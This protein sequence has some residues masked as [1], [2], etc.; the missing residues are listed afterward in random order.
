MQ[1]VLVDMKT[2]R[3]LKHGSKAALLP[4]PPTAVLGPESGPV[5]P[6][7]PGERAGR[8]PSP[9]PT[10]GGSSG[11][12]HVAAQALSLA[13]SQGA[14]QTDR[15]TSFQRGQSQP[16]GDQNG[17]ER[18]VELGADP[19]AS[20]GLAGCAPVFRRRLRFGDGLAGGGA[21]AAARRGQ[22]PSSREQETP[23]Q[24]PTGDQ[25]SEMAAATG[26]S[27]HLS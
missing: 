1:V 13:A 17:V 7:S 6:A 14:I 4:L 23:L 12:G 15:D 26:E 19:G 3:K 9:A 25:H 18:S 20:F 24:H 11:D 8:E 27:S 21:V 5:S 22:P 2:P 16:G 10:A